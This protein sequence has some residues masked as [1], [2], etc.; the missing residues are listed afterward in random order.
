MKKRAISA[1]DLFL[2]ISFSGTI[3]FLLV[4]LLG[5]GTAQNG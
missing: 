3:I 5:G 4:L 1:Y 2:I